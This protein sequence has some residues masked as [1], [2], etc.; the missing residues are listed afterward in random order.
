MAYLI[1]ILEDKVRFELGRLKLE[2]IAL[3]HQLEELQKQLS[4]AN[5]HNLKEP[6]HEG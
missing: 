5:L 2:N 6:G 4:E 3:Q 1:E